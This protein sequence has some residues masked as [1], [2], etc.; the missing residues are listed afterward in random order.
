MTH[1]MQQSATKWHTKLLCA[2]EAGF[3]RT[4]RP[5]PAVYLNAGGL[6]QLGICHDRAIQAMFQLTR[7]QHYVH[8]GLV[9]EVM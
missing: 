2:Y 6:F 4:A 8:F 1:L 7:K 3:F 9:Y 5:C